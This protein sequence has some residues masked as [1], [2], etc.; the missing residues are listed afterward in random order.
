MIYLIVCH[1]ADGAT[2]IYLGCQEAV[3][4]RVAKEGACVVCTKGLSV[5]ERVLMGGVQADERVKD[6]GWDAS[7]GW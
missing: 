5:T 4:V 3:T 7:V 1:D 2:A 6:T